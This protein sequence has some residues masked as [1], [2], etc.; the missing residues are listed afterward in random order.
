MKTCTLCLYL[1]IAGYQDIG[2]YV[3]SILISNGD[4][5]FPLEP[6]YQVLM[7][8]LNPKR[9]EHCP[10]PWFKYWH[11]LYLIHAPKHFH[12]FKNLTQTHLQHEVGSTFVCTP[13]EGRRLRVLVTLPHIGHSLLRQL[14]G[15]RCG[16]PH[17][18]CPN[19]LM[20]QTVRPGPRIDRYAPVNQ[21]QEIKD[22]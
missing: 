16:P 6:D 20:S 4:Q 3:A 8:T 5:I 22:M 17:H 10:R 14:G 12:A 7:D 13:S 15:G 21:K 18:G 11:E 2:Y 19:S 9:V 1:G